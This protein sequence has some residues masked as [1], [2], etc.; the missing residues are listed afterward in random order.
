MFLLLNALARVFNGDNGGTP[1]PTLGTPIAAN[2]NP[3]TTGDVATLLQD[4]RATAYA[5]VL[6]RT[7]RS[8]QPL[9]AH[10]QMTFDDLQQGTGG[11]MTVSPP[12]AASG[13]CLV[14]SRADSVRLNVYSGSD[15]LFLAGLRVADTII[16]TYR[17]V[18]TES[19]WPFGEW[20][21]W[22][23]SGPRIPARLDPWGR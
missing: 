4:T 20:R 2:S 17:I 13:P 19:G 14:R 8:G 21:A 10:L 18:G 1:A 3:T 9:H 7:T 11:Y 22:R 5:G 23:I 16:G 15:T 6:S 12:L